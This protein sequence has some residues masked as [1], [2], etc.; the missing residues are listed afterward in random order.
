MKLRLPDVLLLLVALVGGVLAW[1]TGRERGRLGDKYERMAR[2][3]GDLVV[4]DRSRIHVRALKTGDPMHFAWRVYLPA[5][6][7]LKAKTNLGDSGS[8]WS[9]EPQEFIARVRFL[10][11]EHGVLN[12]YTRL[13]GGSSRMGLGDPKLAELVR[14]RWGKLL[15]EQMGATELFAVEP[16]QPAVLLKL[17]LPDDMQAEAR[18]AL[19]PNEQARFI[20]AVFRLEFEPL[21]PKQ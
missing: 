15:V 4:T 10:E 18:K 8:S 3:T 5:N 9:S 6:C 13:S 1:Q 11:D 19:Y 21:V 7:T 17:T 2:K 20:P 16:D 12:L 14:G